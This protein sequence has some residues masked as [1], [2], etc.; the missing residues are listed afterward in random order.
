M[1][2]ISEDV[3]KKKTFVR[4]LSTHVTQ[5]AS[6]GEVQLGFG[7]WLSLQFTPIVKLPNP[8]GTSPEEVT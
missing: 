8:I 4:A 2:N 5:Q 3:Q 7:K 1:L 6:A